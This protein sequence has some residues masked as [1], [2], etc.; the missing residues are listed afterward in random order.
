MNFAEWSRVPYMLS[1]PSH[2]IV[3]FQSCPQGPESHITPVITV[4]EQK[5][6][7]E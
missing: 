6:R 3:G 5:V 4:Q 1:S 7:K 2:R